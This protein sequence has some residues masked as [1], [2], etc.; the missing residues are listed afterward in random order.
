MVSTD[1]WTIDQWLPYIA[2]LGPDEVWAK[3]KAINSLEFSRHLMRGGLT[4]SEV[5]LL[6]KAFADRHREL[7]ITPASGGY[8]DLTR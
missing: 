1:K 5:S 6:F 4:G 3:A 8:V 2:S 7:G